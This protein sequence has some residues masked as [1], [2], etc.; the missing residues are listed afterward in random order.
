VAA[1]AKL[2]GLTFGVELG[3]A[4]GQEDSYA[5]AH[6]CQDDHKEPEPAAGEKFQHK[7]TQCEGWQ[8]SEV[9]GCS[10]AVNH[11]A[12]SAGRQVKGMLNKNNKNVKN[13]FLYK[14][15][16]VKAFPIAFRENRLVQAVMNTIPKKWL[17]I[18][19]AHITSSKRAYY[20]HIAEHNFIKNKIVLHDSYLLFF[21]IVTLNGL[22]FAN[23]QQPDRES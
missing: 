10:R 16:K 5:C 22:F 20:N 17:F 6:H 11:T 8:T 21:S 23:S 18:L 3:G 4:E 1:G 14:Q 2:R 9:L 13:N 19:F 15:L 12:L 7:R